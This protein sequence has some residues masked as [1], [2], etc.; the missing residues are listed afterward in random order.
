MRDLGINDDV[1][2]VNGG[3]IALRPPDRHVGRVVMTLIH[4]CGGGGGVG[5]TAALC[6]AA[7]A[8]ATPR[9]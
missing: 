3:A 9:S 2:S 5:T 8:R 7:A 1:V 6:L 4:E